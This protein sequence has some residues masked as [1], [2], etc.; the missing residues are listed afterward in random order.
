LPFIHATKRNAEDL[1]KAGLWHTD[2][3]GWSINGWS[4]FQI[5][6]DAAKERSHK[7]REAALKRWHGTK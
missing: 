4:E 7:S 2:M 5:S 3:G 6:D 1:V